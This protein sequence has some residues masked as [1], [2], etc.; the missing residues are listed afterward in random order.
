MK[1]YEL[2][3]AMVKEL[4]KYKV[5]MAGI[6]ETKWLGQFVYNVGGFM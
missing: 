1:K 3:T 5:N 6:S 4:K 2:N